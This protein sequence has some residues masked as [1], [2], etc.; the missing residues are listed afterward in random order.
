MTN[1]IEGF[2]VDKILINSSLILSH[3]TIFIFI[4]WFLIAVL[5]AESS[6]KFNLDAK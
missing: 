6:L 5:H 2:S 4:A 3:E 1:P